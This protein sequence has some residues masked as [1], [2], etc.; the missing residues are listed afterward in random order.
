MEMKLP[1]HPMQYGFHFDNNFTMHVLQIGRNGLFSTGGLCGGMAETVLDY[2]KHVLPIPTHRPAHFGTPDGVPPEGSR[3]RDYIPWR[4]LT[5]LLRNG[6]TRFIVLPWSDNAAWYSATPTSEFA[7]LQRHLGPP[8]TPGDFALLCLYGAAGLLT[9]PQVLAYG[10]NDDSSFSGQG[11]WIYDSIHPDHEVRRRPLPAPATGFAV[12]VDGV[13]QAETYKSCFMHDEGYDLANPPRPAYVDLGLDVAIAVSSS[14]IH[15]GDPL[16]ATMTARKCCDFA[17]HF[18]AL[19]LFV[20]YLT[21]KAV[22]HS[23]TGS[24]APLAPSM[25]V[26]SS[27]ATCGT[28]PCGAS[29]G[30]TC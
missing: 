24:A 14:T 9:G 17:A 15:A 22:P 8:G 3:L 11:V 4:Q 23:Q 20:G 29:L 27:T 16:D 10:W 7:R 12:F 6:G 19:D 30:V 25:T 28:V 26:L 13:S 5:T 2:Y 18:S 21:Y 1:F